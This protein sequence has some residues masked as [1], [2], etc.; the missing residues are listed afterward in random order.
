M[1]TAAVG[2]TPPLR[3][4]CTPSCSGQNTHTETAKQQLFICLNKTCKR[5]G[6]TQVRIL[7]FQCQASCCCRLQLPHK[8][9]LTAAPCRW[10]SLQRIWALKSWRSPVPAAKVILPAPPTQSTKPSALAAAD[11]PCA[12]QESVA[13]A[14]TFASCRTTSRSTTSPPRPSSGSCWTRSAACRSQT[15]C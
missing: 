11:T 6:S 9:Q 4:S 10:H 5:Q 13:M 8:A 2:R 14:P 12:V 3:S 7:L 15:A 1:L